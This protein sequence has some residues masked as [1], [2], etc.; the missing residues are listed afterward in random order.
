MVGPETS[1]KHLPLEQTL[2]KSS[3]SDSMFKRASGEPPAL[4]L[5]LFQALACLAGRR[6]GARGCFSLTPI[7]IMCSPQRVIPLRKKEPV[8]FRGWPCADLAKTIAGLRPS[9]PCCSL[10]QGAAGGTDSGLVWAK[11]PAK[12]GLGVSFLLF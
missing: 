12:P 6:P 10:P 9:R 2:L 1:L 4:G 3:G 5:F 8:T 11:P 7:Q